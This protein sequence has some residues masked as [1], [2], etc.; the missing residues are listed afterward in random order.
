MSAPPELGPYPDDRNRQNLFVEADPEYNALTSAP[1]GSSSAIDSST[2]RL[3]RRGRGLVMPVDASSMSRRAARRDAAWFTRRKIAFGQARAFAGHRLR[4]AD[5]EAGRLL[6]RLASRR[7]GG[8][9]AAAT[10]GVLLVALTWLVLAVREASVGHVAVEERLARVTV[11]LRIDQARFDALSI[12]LGQAELAA[13]Q[14]RATIT[15]SRPCRRATQDK[16]TPVPHR[17]GRR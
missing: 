17:P 5:L 10:L 16:P 14:P 2:V 6:H 9:A 11:A 8:L 3:P 13:G 4:Q 1:T 7:Y 15:A 12:K